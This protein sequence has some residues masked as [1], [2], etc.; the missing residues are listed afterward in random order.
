M[1]QRKPTA[2][3]SAAGES[4]AGESVVGGSAAGESTAGESA[5]SM[6]AAA[7]SVAGASA[8]PP[9]TGEPAAAE[10]AAGRLAAGN[11]ARITDPQVMRALAHP[12]RIEIMEHLGSTGA[13]VTATE[14]AG[15][16][17]LSPSATSYHLRELA[18]YGLVEQAPSRGDARERVW[19]STSAGWSVGSDRQEPEAWA[20]ERALI[21]VYVT[22]DFARLR[23][24]FA[25]QH[26]EPQ[27]WRESS[28]LSG[29]I[30]LLTAEEL[31]AVDQA[32]REVLYPYRRRERM[33][34]PPDDARTVA[35]H[36][37]AFPVD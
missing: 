9:A 2:S 15:Q 31:R 14:M 36:F 30:L 19:R 32:V 27:E 25:R 13:V 24:W 28:V 35:V 34:E 3:E 12:A 10:S 6:S 4:V 21:D 23:D 33:A 7:E 5:T 18:K 22:R 20:A 26:E 17:G 11:S 1:A 16:V 29:S 37:A 8:A